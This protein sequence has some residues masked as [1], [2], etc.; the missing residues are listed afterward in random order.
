[1]M[2]ERL[3]LAVALFAVLAGMIFAD[4]PKVPAVAFTLER[5]RGNPGPIAFALAPE[6]RESMSPGAMSG[7]YQEYD[8][9]TVIGLYAFSSNTTGENNTAAGY[10]ALHYNTEG[11]D[12]VAAGKAALINNTEGFSNSAIGVNTLAQNA[13]GSWNTAI[14]ISALNRNTTGSFNTAVG[15]QA[16]ADCQGSWNIYL[17]ADT[18][19]TPETDNNTIRIGMPFTG[20]P[21]LGQNRTFIAGIVQNP[22]TLA[23]TEVPKVVGVLSTGQ[24]GTVPAELLPPGPQGPQGDTGATGPAGPA[25]PAGPRGPAGPG[26]VPGSIIMLPTSIAPPAGYVLLGTTSYMMRLPSGRMTLLNLSIYQKT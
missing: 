25:G 14:G 22:F 15:T 13:S 18:G 2:K 24:L 21:A 16:G 3:S 17:G 23:D 6:S 7:A 9:N 20:S 11:H 19:G 26:P 8:T 1:M 4:G 12:N 10:Y 5:S